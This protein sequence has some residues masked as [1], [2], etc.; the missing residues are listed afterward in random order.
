MPSPLIRDLEFRLSGVLIE[1]PYFFVARGRLKLSS[2]VV[3]P[4]PLHFL[5]PLETKIKKRGSKV[6][7]SNR[8]AFS[9]LFVL[10]TSFR[11]LNVLSQ[12]FALSPCFP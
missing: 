3:Y 6:R 12:V 10:G 8:R 9:T 5:H 1:Q 4:P 11:V 7:S 2:V